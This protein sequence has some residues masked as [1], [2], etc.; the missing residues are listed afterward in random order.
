MLILDNLANVLDPRVQPDPALQKHHQTGPTTT[1]P[2]NAT[3]GPHKVRF[4]Q[5]AISQ[6]VILANR[7]NRAML[8]MSLILAYCPILRSRR[9]ILQPDRINPMRST[10]QIRG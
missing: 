4:G 8:L 3:V 7:M 10:V 5:I 2:A 1:D 6:L 9:D